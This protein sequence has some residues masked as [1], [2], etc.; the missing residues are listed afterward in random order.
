LD[1]TVAPWMQLSPLGCNCRS[2]DATVAPW[3]Q[4]SPLGCNHGIPPIKQRNVYIDIMTQVDNYSEMEYSC[5]KWKPIFS[6]REGALRPHA[7][8]YIIIFHRAYVPKF[9]RIVEG[10]KPLIYAAVLC[11]QAGR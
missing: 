6:A 11:M 8:L 4:L 10:S 7:P 1:A 9:W 2:L 3:M 5:L